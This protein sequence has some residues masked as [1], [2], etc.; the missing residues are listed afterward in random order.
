MAFQKFSGGAMS[1]PLVLRDN[2]GGIAQLILPPP[3]RLNAL[4]VALT[5]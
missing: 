3:T 1:E 2:A 5:Q 4:S